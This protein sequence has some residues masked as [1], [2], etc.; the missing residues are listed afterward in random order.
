MKGRRSLQRLV[1][2]GLLLVLVGRMDPAEGQGPEKTAGPETQEGTAPLALPGTAFTYQGRLTNG[3]GPVSGTCSFVFGL[4]DEAGSGIPPTGGTLLGTESLSGEDV[5]DG[6]FTVQLDFGPGTFTGEARWLEIAVDCGGGS[7][8]LSPR[9]ELTPTPLALALPGLWTQ[10]DASSPNLIGGYPG[11]WVTSG[12]M[13]ATIGGGGE[14]GSQNR[15]T[16]NHG[17]IGGGNNNQAGNDSIPLDDAVSATVAGGYG[18]IASGYRSAIGGGGLNLA[19]SYDTTIGGGYENE[20][21]FYSATVGGGYQNKATGGSATVC[22]GHANIASGSFST[23]CGGGSSEPLDTSTSNRAT[24]DYATVGGGG[25]NQAGNANQDP[26]DAKYSTVAGG[27]ENEASGL[28]SVVGGG[29]LNVSN[30]TNA[31]I[32]GGNN[33]VSGAYAFVGGGSINVA[34]GSGAVIGGGGLNTASATNTTIGG[35]VYN[36]ATATHASVLGGMYNEAAGDYATIG[37]GGGGTPTAGNRVTNDYSTVGGGTANAV[38]GNYATIGGGDE[39]TAS[40]SRGT[41]AGG[42][43]NAAGGNYSFVGG[44]W[45]NA[46]GG[47]YSIV[48]G[49]NSST[50]QGSFSFA[51]GRHA[52]AYNSGCF[53]W[54]DGSSNDD[55][56]CNDNDRTIF[57]STGGFYIF[58]DSAVTPSGLYLAAGGSSWNTHSDREAKENLQPVDATDVVARLAGIPIAT[59]NYRSQDPSIRHIGPMAQDF[60]T[61]VDGLGGEGE[62]YVNS[63]DADGVALAAIQG[64]YQL[65]QEQAARIEELE[66]QNSDLEARLIALEQ[67]AESHSQ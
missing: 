37:G 49:G 25:N 8:T 54:A 38:S 64:L 48:P 31:T 5:S 41:V 44:G 27:S 13:G 45:S 66:L 3:S 7:V 18:N 42:H 33:N 59:W 32:S 62:T 40:G 30:G 55:T 23:I 50:A 2:L 20:A 15:V 67:A 57:R 39:N 56:E 10:Q 53:V 47:M 35:G 61:L 28:L 4:Y 19:S 65:S 46:A 43:G 6:L 17:T 63:L 52:K 29:S 51:A 34:S 12:V 9:Q 16:D 26:T 14:A 21:S 1:A 36:E 60:N 58:T 24:D 11:N 22:G